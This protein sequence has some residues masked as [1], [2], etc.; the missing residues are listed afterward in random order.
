MKNIN[1]Q[2]NEITEPSILFV[3]KGF[4]K[5]LYPPNQN[6]EEI[7]DSLNNKF[8][9]DPTKKKKKLHTLNKKTKNKKTVSYF[10][11]K[12]KKILIPIKATKIVQTTL[13]FQHP[14]NTNLK[15]KN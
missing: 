6:E 15:S 1:K 11:F 14:K 8:V 7:L 3:T 10:K 5:T 12:K 13:K 4:V 2:A 9:R